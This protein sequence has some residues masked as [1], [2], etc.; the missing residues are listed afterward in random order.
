[1]KG[2][3]TTLISVMTVVSM[4]TTLSFTRVVNA[5]IILTNEAFPDVVEP[6]LPPCDGMSG[7]VPNIKIYDLAID[8]KNKALTAVSFTY[9]GINK[10]YGELIFRS[11]PSEPVMLKTTAATILNGKSDYMYSINLQ[12]ISLTKDAE[13]AIAVAQDSAPRCLV[14]PKLIPIIRLTPLKN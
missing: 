2:I 1:M 11:S 5:N 4:A 7:P 10:L 6:S 8:S 3:S 13:I 9:P 14:F 12:N